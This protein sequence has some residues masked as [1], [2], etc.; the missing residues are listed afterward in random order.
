M[1]VDLSEKGYLMFFKP[2]QIE[3][4]NH[5][6]KIY[7]EGANSRQVTKTVNNTT[8]IS[9][10]SVIN[11]LNELVDEEL[12][13]YTETTGKGG[14]HRIYSMKGTEQEFKQILIQRIVTKLRN[15]FPRI[16]AFTG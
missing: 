12:L 3:A 4:L 5:L 9:R 13:N 8:K 1:K 10:A 6:K 11:F 16:R 14:H 7:P 2:W 15:E